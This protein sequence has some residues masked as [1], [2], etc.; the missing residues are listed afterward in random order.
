LEYQP[1]IDLKTD[2]IVSFEALARMHSSKLGKVSP[3]EF[4]QAA[5]DSCQI[6]ALGKIVLHKAF[7][8][9]NQLA[10]IGRP[11]IILCVNISALQL[12]RDSFLPDLFEL[13]EKYKID[14]SVVA[15]GVETIEQ[16]QYLIEHNCDYM[17]GYLFS[18]PVP[19]EQ[20]IAML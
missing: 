16:K 3:F 9:L 7:A 14:H 20:A 4:I 2:R 15:E 8:F 5:E 10:S 13:M 12:L 11:D 18:K 1:I 17:Q 6:Y 19:Q